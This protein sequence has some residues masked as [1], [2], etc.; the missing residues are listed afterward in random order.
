MDPEAEVE[1]WT[2]LEIKEEWSAARTVTQM[3]MPVS[4]ERKASHKVWLS[5]MSL[6]ASSLASPR[7]WLLQP[8]S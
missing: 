3:V 6:T 2:Q 5:T 7:L 8:R 1:L 4:T